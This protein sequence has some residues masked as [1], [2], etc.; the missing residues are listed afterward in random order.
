[1]MK[2]PFLLLALLMLAV[3]ATAQTVETGRADWDKFPRVKK[4]QRPL[5]VS[6]LSD[7]AES[8]LSSGECRVP[9][10]SPDKFD[11]DIPYAALVEPDGTV[12]R[13]IM[14]DA[15]CPGLNT[16]VGS[17]IYDWVQRGDF[18]PTGKKEPLWFAG[19]VAFAR[20]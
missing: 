11:I 20:E 15:G 8:V 16:M 4:K 13:V 14:A 12:K 18:K 1:M 6:R 9:G 5:D 3:P 19:R 7:W 10:M 2:K 17:T